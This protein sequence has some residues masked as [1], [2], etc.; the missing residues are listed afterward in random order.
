MLINMATKQDKPNS[1]E[2]KLMN[3]TIMRS[4]PN[5]MFSRQMAIP[6]RCR[7]FAVT[8][9]LLV[10]CGGWTAV[11]G[12]VSL[13]AV[14][15]LNTTSF[16]TAGHWSS[17][18]APV[19]GNGYVV[20]NLTL[21]SPTNL[22]SI[23][24]FAGDS[25]TI[26]GASG[27]F[28]LKTTNVI[29]VSNLTLN[30]SGIVLSSYG[31]GAPCILGGTVNI[32]SGGGVFDPGSYT[33]AVPAK[34]TGGGTLTIQHPNSVTLSSSNSFNGSLALQGTS[35]ILTG[36]AYLWPSNLTMQ[37]FLSSIYTNAYVTNVVSPGGT[38]NVG[39]GP[40]SVLT[41]GT[42]TSG[43]GQTNCFAT[44]DVSAQSQFTANVG[45]FNVGINDSGFT[46][47]KVSG[48][49]FLATNNVISVAT[50]MLVGDNIS[51]GASGLTNF[52]VLGGGSNYISAAAVTVG[53]SKEVAQLSLPVGG[54]FRLDNNGGA[55][56]L[57]VGSSAIS[58]SANP[59]GDLADFS[60][61]TLLAT[62]GSLLIGQKSGGSSGGMSGAGLLGGSGANSV[63]AHVVT[64]GSLA[65]A[66]AGS[67][68]ASGTLTVGGGSL[69]ATGMVTLASYDN[70]GFGTASGTLNL[71]G[72]TLQA[73]GIVAGG[74]TGT[75][76][77]SGGTLKA[78]IAS[79][80]FL[81]GLTAVTVSTNGAV[82][83]DGGYAITIGQALAHDTALAGADGG[84]TKTG[85]GTLT[86]SGS[87]T[88]NGSTTVNAGTLALG[89]AGSV[90]GSAGI[91]VAAGATFDVSAISAYAL[92]GSQTLSAS[93]SASAA[94]I[95]GAVGGTVSLGARPVTLTYD[96]SDPALTVSQGTLVL[97]G[98]AFTVNGYAPAVGSYVIARQS[99]GNIS[100]SGSFAA[101]GTAIGSGR[102]G[103]ISVSGGN[104]NLVIQTNSATACALTSGSSP[105]A[106]GT[107]LTFTATVS[108]SAPTGNVIFKDGATAL[109]TNTLAGGSASYTTA[110]MTAGSHSI[111]AYYSGDSSN[112]PSDSSASPASQTVNP[113]AVVLS[114]TRT[115]DGTTNAAAGIL[116]ILNIANGDNVT[117]AS[118]AAG[119]AGKSTGSEVIVSPGTLTLGGAQ[120]ANYTVTGVSGSVLVT[121]ATLYVIATDDTKIFCQTVTFAGTEFSLGGLYP[122]DTVTSVTLTSAGATNTAPVG[123][124]N[125][126][127]SAANGSGLGNYTINYVNGTLTVRALWVTGYY[128]GYAT[129][130]MAVSNID[131][132]TITHVV[133]YGLIPNTNGTIDSSTRD[134]AASACTQ[135]VSTAHAAGAKA[136]VCVGGAGMEPNFLGATEPANLGG[137]VTNVYNFMATNGYDGVDVDWE[138]YYAADA[139]QFTNFINSLRTLLGTGKLLTVAAPAHPAP[140]DSVT[141]EF[142]M[143][144]SIQNQ[145]DQINDMTYD[146]ANLSSGATWHNSSVY[147]GGHTYPATGKV[148]PSVNGS[149][150]SF[151]T[152]GVVSSKL[153]IGLP[154]YGYVWT[155]STNGLTSPLQGW[156]GNSVPT[157][158]AQTYATIAGSYYSPAA[159]SWDTNTEA[160]YLGITNLVATNSMFISYDDTNSCRAKVVYSRNQFLGGIVVWELSQ[161]YIATNSPGN[162]M[163]LTAALKQ[164]LSTP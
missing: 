83:N 82:I 139:G 76:K 44:L 75:V 114:G 104:V 23:A 89:A 108:G 144:A 110:A 146:F 148:V 113:L 96:G 41:V 20:T 81:Q 153:G 16:N 33:L 115:Y 131:F 80:T 117:V 136:L 52:V 107:S 155:G 12:T 46:G 54:V 137:F 121:A 74:G 37:S 72:G 48:N 92:G 134:L 15:A 56:N 151:V 160:A 66:N 11:A 85:G 112:T 154:Y 120:A 140:G 142:T 55:A 65:G 60:K 161:E 57:F 31:P 14:D 47:Y 106:Y 91:T 156:A 101:A 145:F 2:P 39:Y 53:G 5:P 17:G 77:F 105:S 109:A 49:V 29:T 34:V 129:S 130:R 1:S 133:H 135:L 58:T 10:G 30:T 97:N 128:P 21:R 42:L 103:S 150:N 8:A 127:P 122:G 22:T 86:L 78:G 4:R 24:P 123:S 126:V 164:A 62:L 116:S 147:D 51:T 102:T 100:S 124:Y 7:F 13:T 50:N 6:C 43:S 68:V 69:V 90:S 19:A 84:L 111:T 87:N 36:N 27:S 45:S 79:G 132:T 93:G 149:L 73:N 159:Y 95:N 28:F 64:V 9:A 67:P 152:N 3:I 98:N 70:S 26:V 40:G 163:P 118:G 38:C 99:S 143:L 162:R 61:G 59:A 94:T 88:Y 157:D 32:A 35:L 71:Y 18:L 63:T 125:I 158:T 141:A 119:L 138:P 25:L